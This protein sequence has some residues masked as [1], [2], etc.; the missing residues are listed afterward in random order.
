MLARCDG[1]L[2]LAGLA[3]GE[4]DNAEMHH[5][6]PRDRD[7]SWVHNLDAMVRSARGHVAARRWEGARQMGGNTLYFVFAEPGGRGG[8]TIELPT[9]GEEMPETAEVAG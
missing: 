8:D 5:S 3:H 7:R 2:V 9:L 1:L 4:T 6:E